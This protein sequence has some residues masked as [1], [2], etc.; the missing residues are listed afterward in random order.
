LVLLVLLASN[1]PGM[2]GQYE[3]TQ[4]YRHINSEL[5]V[6]IPG[7]ANVMGMSLYYLPFR[8]QN[9]YSVTWMDS[10]V[11]KAGL[12][13]E[14]VV[15]MMNIEYIIV[16]DA[17]ASRAN[18]RGKEWADSLKAFLDAHGEVVSDIRTRMLLKIIPVPSK[19]PEAFL[20]KDYESGYVKRILVYKLSLR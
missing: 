16:D 6:I 12:T 13:F 3:A 2:K 1:V 17:F 10:S 4:E 5:A 15:R 8:D 20:H 11:G 19:I 7:N 9:Y 14:K 18:Y